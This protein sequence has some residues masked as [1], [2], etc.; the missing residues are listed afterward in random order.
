[1]TLVTTVDRRNLLRGAAYAGGG[2]ALAPLF[3]AWATSGTH[4]TA[5]STDILSGEDIA[6]SI[7]HE[8]ASILFFG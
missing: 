3:P 2:L 4:G 1:M 6:L 8:P 7:G 5:S